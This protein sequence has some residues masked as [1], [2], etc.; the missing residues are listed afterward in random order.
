M[1][2]P[3]VEQIAAV[4]RAAGADARLE[5]LPQGERS[6]P[7]SEVRAEAVDCDGRLV[8]ALV[9]ADR[10]TDPERLVVAAHCKVVRTA[11]PPPFPYRGA[12]VLIE[13]LLLGEQTVWIEAGSPRHAA[14]RSPSQLARLVQA[15]AADLL[16]EP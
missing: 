2:P 11:N 1:W 12:K 4:F 13:R 9:P 16:A 14:V 5:E 8:I 15:E 10:E 3:P 6:F 7:G